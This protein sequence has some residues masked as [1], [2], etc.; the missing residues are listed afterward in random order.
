MHFQ[1]QV[2]NIR[3]TLILALLTGFAQSTFYKYSLKIVI[4][5][6]S[7]KIVKWFIATSSPLLYDLKSK[8]CLSEGHWKD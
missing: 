5:D 2:F 1:I 7:E 6:C 3:W 4:A 8:V